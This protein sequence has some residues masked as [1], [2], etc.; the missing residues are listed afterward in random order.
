MEVPTCSKCG[1]T[2]RLVLAGDFEIVCVQS[3][4]GCGAVY[5]WTEF[6]NLYKPDVEVG[7]EK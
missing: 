4:G 7:P 2:H 6:M 5:S 1:A 3:L